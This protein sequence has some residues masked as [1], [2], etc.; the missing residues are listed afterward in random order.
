MVSKPVRWVK[1]ALFLKHPPPTIGT[2]HA[3]VRVPS[4]K[5][6]VGVGVSA[7][8]AAGLAPGQGFQLERRGG[9][10]KSPVCPPGYFTQLRAATCLSPKAPAP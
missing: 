8:A 9:C 3:Q 1:R 7:A 5:R 2:R 4:H 6:S 10:K